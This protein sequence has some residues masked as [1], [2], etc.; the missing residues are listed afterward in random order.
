MK[1]YLSG[2]IKHDPNYVKKF[3]KW[4]EELELKDI[5]D[6]VVN[7][8]TITAHQPDFGYHDFMRED[9]RAMLDCTHIAFIP[10]WEQST[11]ARV[12]LTVAVAIGIK[13]VFL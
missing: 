13:I 1:I 6:E 3:A 7:P 8:V 10:G 9:I 11:G 12:E 5:W 4:Q 2:S